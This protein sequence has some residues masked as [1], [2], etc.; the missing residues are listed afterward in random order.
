M[1]VTVSRIN[2]LQ[3]FHYEIWNTKDANYLGLPK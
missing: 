1:E 3:S 2:I